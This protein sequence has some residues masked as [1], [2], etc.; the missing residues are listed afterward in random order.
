VK[1]RGLKV[2]EA[3]I[4][5]GST[6]EAALELAVSQNAV[7]RS[8]HESS[9]EL[10]LPLVTLIQGRLEP[11]PEARMLIR[12]AAGSLS[13]I[14]RT[15]QEATKLRAGLVGRLR[16]VSI[17]SLAHS[18]LPQALGR[19]LQ[20]ERHARPVE[21]AIDQVEE[22]L[23]DLFSELGFSFGLRQSTSPLTT[24]PLR[25]GRLVCVLRSDDPLTRRN[26]ID[27]MA[28]AGRTLISYATGEPNR[29]DSLQQALASSGVAELVNIEV[30]HNNTACHLVH[31]GCGVAIVDEFVIH[32]DL[33]QGLL[34]RPLVPAA[35]I[36]AFAHYRADRPPQ[37]AA[38]RLLE[39]LE[40]MLQPCD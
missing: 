13:A 27:L 24:Y 17:P 29:R 4:R 7:I 34:V 16:L 26:E 6:R 21:L 14:G 36:T 28:L 38:L 8:L 37:V 35:P 33:A 2:L 11:T 32:S 22:R 20:E 3:V 25:Q 31:E 10:D 18:I 5:H 30:L 19:L 23:L 12:A 40:E 15:K 1:L 9:R 39:L